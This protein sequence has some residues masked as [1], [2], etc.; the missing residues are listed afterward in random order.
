[1]TILRSLNPFTRSQARTRTAELFA[2][3]LRATHSFSLGLRNSPH[4]AS[5][6]FQ[7]SVIPGAFFFSKCLLLGGEIPNRLKH[8]RGGSGRGLG[9]RG[10]G[11]LKGVHQQ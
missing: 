1:M 3:A 10:F 5:R 7:L 11:P 2:R 9:R 8:L 4:P 6:E